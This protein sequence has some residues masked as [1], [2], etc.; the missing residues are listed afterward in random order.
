MDTIKLIARNGEAVRHA[1]ELGDIV[2]M[3]T[4]NEE[5]T[6]ELLLFAVNSGLLQGWATGFPDPRQEAEIGMDVLWAA[7][8]AARFA[9]LYSLRTLGDV[10][11]LA[12]VLGALGSRV[13]VRQAGK[14]MARRGTGDAQVVS[15]DV[16]RQ[17]VVQRE[18]PIT[19]S[20]DELAQEVIDTRVGRVRQRGS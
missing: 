14:G 12:R 2:H 7:S 19:V 13:D 16:L 10:L 5:L 15:G 20:Q 8:V 6:D 18:T 17:L 11:Q 1:I 9:G 4:A 3:D